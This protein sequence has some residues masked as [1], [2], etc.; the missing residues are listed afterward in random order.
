ME[1]YTSNFCP[2]SFTCTMCGEPH[3]K[4]LPP[5]TKMTSCGKCGNLIT[6]NRATRNIQAMP[7]GFRLPEMTPYHIPNEDS[8]DFDCERYLDEEEEFNQFINVP[9][10]RSNN[11]RNQSNSNGMFFIHVPNDRF[12]NRRTNRRQLSQDLI[13]EEAYFDRVFEEE[14]NNYLNRQST[15]FSGINLP[16]LKTTVIPP[17]PKLKKTPMTRKLYTKNAKGKLEAPVCCICLTNMKLND[18]IV[19]LKCK[20]MFH[21]PCLDKWIQT[22]EECPFCRGKVA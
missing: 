15:V 14:L 17:K 5:G 22:K 16:E 8:D 1:S 7:R 6:I 11:Q 21:H 20:H 10:T 4:Y 19:Q 3:L 12:D 18:Q 13:D 2:V 9:M